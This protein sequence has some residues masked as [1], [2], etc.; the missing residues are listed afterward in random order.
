[1]D[2]TRRLFIQTARA[3]AFALT[4]HVRA[5]VDHDQSSLAV[6]EIFVGSLQRHETVVLQPKF[7]RESCY[8]GVFICCS[9]SSLIAGSTSCDYRY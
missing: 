2:L 7:D 9:K 8:A 6:L 5:T 4:V 1:M 3:A